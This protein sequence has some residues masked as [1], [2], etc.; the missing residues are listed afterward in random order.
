LPTRA[1]EYNTKYIQHFTN[2][3]FTVVHFKKG[4]SIYYHDKRVGGERGGK[5]D[6]G[7]DKILGERGKV[8]VLCV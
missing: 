6:R 5:R 8:L 4:D 1:H 2:I 3:N 7:R